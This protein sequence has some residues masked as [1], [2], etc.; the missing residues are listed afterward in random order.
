MIVFGQVKLASG[1][2]LRID[3]ALYP[4]RRL[5]SR[6][7]GQ[8]FLCVIMEEN[9]GLILPGPWTRA[10]TMA[11]PKNRQK[12]FIRDLAGIIVDLDGLGVIA[13]IMVSRILFRASRI[14]H[15]GAHHAFEDPEPGVRTPESP[16]G[17]GGGFDLGRRRRVYGRYPGFTGCCI[18]HHCSFFRHW[19]VSTSSC[20]QLS[21]GQ[22]QNRRQSS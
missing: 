18:L 22:K 7:Q 9:G 19:Q 8:S 4:C 17:K 10:G 3:F 6:F 5:V 2:N 20:R 12:L 11:L 14:S 16:Q 13:K 1:K 21:C 15:P